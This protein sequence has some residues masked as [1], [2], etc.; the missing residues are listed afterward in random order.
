MITKKRYADEAVMI[1]EREQDLQTLLDK[2]VREGET[3]GIEIDE[4]KSKI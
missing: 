2:N 1:A 3:Y 4:M